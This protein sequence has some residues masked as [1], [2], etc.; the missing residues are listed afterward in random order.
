MPD[1]P[2]L[3]GKR[4]RLDQTQTADLWSRAQYQ[5]ESP[6]KK[7]EEVLAKEIDHICFTMSS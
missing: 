2:K 3:H 1:T 4:T 6:I 7:I 5:V